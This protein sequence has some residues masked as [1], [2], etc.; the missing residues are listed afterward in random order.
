MNKGALIKVWGQV[1]KMLKIINSPKMPSHV[2]TIAIGALLYTI[3]PI[4]AIP[5][6]IPVAGLVDDAAVITFAFDQINKLIKTR[7]SINSNH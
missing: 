6:Y 4:D 2:K 3:I 1:V 7:T 5:D